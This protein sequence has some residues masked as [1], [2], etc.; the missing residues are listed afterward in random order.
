MESR[1]V[2]SCA[3]CLL[4]VAGYTFGAFREVLEY[5]G[6]SPRVVPAPLLLYQGTLLTACFSLLACHVEQACACVCIGFDSNS[7]WRLSWLLSTW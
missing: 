6:F 3:H 2:T 7:V 5:Y 4:V 1:K